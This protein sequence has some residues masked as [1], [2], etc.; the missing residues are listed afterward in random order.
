MKFVYSFCGNLISKLKHFWLAKFILRLPIIK[1][2]LYVKQFV[3]FIL[4]GAISA[5][6]DFTVYICLTRFFVFWQAHY[7]WAN[8]MAM[9]IAST[10]N[11]V[12]NRRWTFKNGR[13]KM[14]HQYMKFCIVLNGGLFFYQFLFGCFVAT[15]NWY[16]IIA[17]AIIASM[18][19]FIRFQLQKFWIFK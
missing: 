7:L 1:K 16:D 11:F 4:V 10:I 17:K 12:L 19:G 3:K 2:N 9:I 8:F 15:L 6:I 14:L 18:I 13:R 5:L